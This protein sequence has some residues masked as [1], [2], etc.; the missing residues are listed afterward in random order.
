MTQQVQTT[1]IVKIGLQAPSFNLPSTL[2]MET[3]EEN[4]T[5]ESYRGKWLM[6]FFWPYDFTYVCPTEIIAFSDHADSFR[7][8]DCEIVGVS[9]DS[10]YTHRAW[11][12]TPRDQQGIGSINYPLASDF[13]KE[14][15]RAYG[16]LDE[17]SGSAHRG[18][19]IIDPEGVVRYQ[20]VT[21]M[22]VGRS[23]EET[24]RILQALQAGGLCPVNW[25][26]GEKTLG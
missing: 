14:T 2:N 23:V 18:L 4:V 1:E 25:K 9:V 16:V 24:L 20:V 15:A 26:P 12:Q 6:L 7:D 10:V 3:L 17:A 19:F 11:T 13:K 21:D 8:L 22:N 5:L